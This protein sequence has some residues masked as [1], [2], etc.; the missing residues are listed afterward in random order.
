M[1]KLRP[2]ITIQKLNQRSPGFL[3]GHMGLEMLALSENTLTSRMPIQSFHIAPNTF[4][5][6]GSEI[7][8]AD[9][10]C[11][12]ATVAHLPHGASSFTTIE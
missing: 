2:D 4:L 12:Y 7:T 5:H 11:G 8:L 3:P 6:A 1:T 10:T 9:T